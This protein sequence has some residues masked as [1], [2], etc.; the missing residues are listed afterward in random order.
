[1]TENNRE[2]RAYGPRTIPIFAFRHTFLITDIARKLL[3]RRYRIFFHKPTAC[4]VFTQPNEITDRLIRPEQ[5]ALRAA[6][7]TILRPVF[8]TKIKTGGIFP[9]FSLKKQIGPRAICIY[10][11][12]AF[13]ILACLVSVLSNIKNVKNFCHA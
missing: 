8:L 7:N 6:S 11:N 3:D 13:K 1:M 10:R 12:F 9:V 5:W 4:F 2:K